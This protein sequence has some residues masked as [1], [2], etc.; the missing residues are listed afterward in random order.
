MPLWFSNSSIRREDPKTLFQVMMPA[1]V[2]SSRGR[3]VPLPLSKLSIARWLARG[4]IL[5]NILINREE[6]LGYFS[7][8]E[9]KLSVNARH[10]CRVVKEM[11]EYKKNYLYF[12]LASPV[13]Q[14]YESINS[15][16]QHRN[17]DSNDLSKQLI[18]RH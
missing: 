15:L 7:T 5:Y 18:I 3:D 16:F 11:F 2:E 13:V 9:T 10:K 17:R 14:E 1:D 8:Y 4:K 12:V 6:L